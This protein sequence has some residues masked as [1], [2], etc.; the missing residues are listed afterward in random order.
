MV[1]HMGTDRILQFINLY[2]IQK[3][4]HTIKE[5]TAQG[6]RKGEV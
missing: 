3:E 4:E 5:L 6:P 1:N 2:G